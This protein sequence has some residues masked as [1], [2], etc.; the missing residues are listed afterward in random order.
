MAKVSH[1]V[2]GEPIVHSLSPVLTALVHSHLSRIEG[3]TL[4]GLK[5]VVV[6]PT[7][8]VENALAWGYAGSLP[9]PPVWELVGSPL[10]KFRANTLL[11]RAVTASID[12][13]PEADPRLPNAPLPVVN[14]ESV[15]V[16]DDEVWLSLTSPLKHQLSAAAVKCIDNAMEIRSVNT[17]R[18]DGQSWWA[19]STDGPGMLIVAEVFGH[20][21]SSVLG[22]NG[23]GGT[24]RS[25]A[26]AWCA[27]GGTINQLG[28][29]RLLEDDGPWVF[30]E[31]EPS[32]SIDFDNDGG[33]LLVR[34]TPMDGD[35]DSRIEKLSNVA[36]GRWLLCAQHLMSWAS[37]WAPKYAEHLPSISLL[38]TRLVAVEVHLG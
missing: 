1:G 19:A 16:Y 15:S 24:A 34:Y 21:T 22:I 8:G 6:I 38:M 35:Y 31:D 11:D 5:G 13:H 7:E 4:P 36:D 9:S 18:W 37:L 26:A 10:G 3:I 25:V 2:A 12:A 27:R 33:D 29:N 14:F 32:I 23:G 20:K 17:L 30:T 28:G